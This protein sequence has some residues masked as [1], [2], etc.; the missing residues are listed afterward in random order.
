MDE[1]KT[2]EDENF[3]V[4][5]E[6]VLQYPKDWDTAK[7]PTVWHALWKEY[8]ELKEAVEELKYVKEKMGIVAVEKMKVK[9]ITD[10]H[11]ERKAEKVVQSQIMRTIILD[12]GGVSVTLKGEPWVLPDLGVGDV[13]KMRISKEGKD[14]ETEKETVKQKVLDY[15]REHKKSDITELHKNIGC[16]IPLLVEIIDELRSEGKIGEG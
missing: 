8:S 1:K 14:N 5:V 13:V 15:T 16:D 11:M 2:L 4:L 6:A 3:K 12:S 9:E 7:Y 10:T